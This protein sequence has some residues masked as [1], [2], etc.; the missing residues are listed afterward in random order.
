MFKDVKNVSFLTA[1]DF[2]LSAYVTGS[3][4]DQFKLIWLKSLPVG[5]CEVLFQHSGVLLVIFVQ[6][7][8]PSLE[9]IKLNLVNI[10]LSS[11]C[12]KLVNQL[13]VFLL[14]RVLQ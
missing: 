5:R 4:L 10:I 14:S 1:L 13:Q 6:S 12:K 3:Q 8:G 7:V 2:Q 11:S 9:T